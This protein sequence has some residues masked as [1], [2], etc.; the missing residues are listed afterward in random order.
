MTPEKVAAFL[1]RDG[2]SQVL[3]LAGAHLPITTA[4][5]N[6]YTR[7]NGFH[8]VDGP[9]DEL[10]AVIIAVTARS[11]TNPDQLQNSS[12]AD[13][14]ETFAPQGFTLPELFVLNRYRKRSQL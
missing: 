4:F 5:V 13:V 10:T 8:P 2:D 6:A 9:N 3:A 12:I 1:G 7:G 14:S 11:V